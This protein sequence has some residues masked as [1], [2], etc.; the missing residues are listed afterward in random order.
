[1]PKFTFN[2]LGDFTEDNIKNI[3]YDMLVNQ[4]IANRA[5][6]KPYTKE[7]YRI[8]NFQE[9]QIRDIL[10]YIEL[11]S[12]NAV[13]GWKLLKALKDIRCERRR[14]KNALESL[15]ILKGMKEQIDLLEQEA[16]KQIGLLERQSRKYIYRSSAVQKTL[17][18]KKK[19]L[20]KVD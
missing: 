4:S 13:D 9:Q 19:Y 2:C 1:M 20:K 8:L 16:R 10:H 5:N 14:V 17:M 3:D 18:F 15:K 11:G 7:L 6:I 12:Y